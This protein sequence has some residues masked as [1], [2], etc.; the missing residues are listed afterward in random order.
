MADPRTANAGAMHGSSSEGPINKQQHRA[1]FASA[2]PLSGDYDEVF[3]GHERGTPIRLMA[4]M[5]GL[6][7]ARRDEPL[8]TA[9]AR[10]HPDGFDF[11]PVTAGQ[12]GPIVGLLRTTDTAA[13]YAA[14]VGDAM[15]PLSGANLIGAD[16]PLLRFVC[17]ADT[18][19]CRL[20]LDG[21]SISGIVTLSDLQRLPVRTA[22]F[23]LFIHLEMF[24]TQTLRDLR[25]G[26]IDPI[27]SL[28]LGK[29]GRARKRWEGAQSQGMQ[30][31]QL[32]VLMF[33]EKR[34]LAVDHAAFANV[35]DRLEQDLAF[36]EQHLRN[37]TAH[38]NEFALT[39]A[40]ARDAADA[41]RRLREWTVWFRD[42]RRIGIDAAAPPA[43]YLTD[44]TTAW[45]AETNDS[46]RRCQ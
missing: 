4:T 27:S 2:S 42:W 31:D 41:A 20:V 35:R 44:R 11:L 17:D 5:T 10:A 6:V 7:T 29:R 45:R 9:L 37:P 3:T 24:L 33:S 36:V 26:G 46:L 23:G 22:V 1:P 25:V 8:T 13:D 43:P 40:S 19:P 28:P 18:I 14:N 32:G 30:R 39:R 16:A 15:D 38:G 21:A 12:H 34:I